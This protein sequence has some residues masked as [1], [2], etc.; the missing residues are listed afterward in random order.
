MDVEALRDSPIGGLVDIDGVDPGT[1]RPFDH[2]AFVPAPLPE[3]VDLTQQ[4]WSQVVNAMGSLGR[5]VQAC[6]QLPN[7]RLLIRPALVKEALSTSAL[8]GTYGTLSDVL[9]A[10]LPESAR[11]TPETREIRAYEMVA[12]QAFQWVEDRP[13]TVGMLSSL[14][15][16]LADAS[17]VPSRDPGQVRQHQ[18][19]IGPEH[20]SVFDARFIP[21]PP[22]IL[23]ETG[24]DDWQRWINE[25]HGL[26]VIVRAALAHYQFESLH[27]FGDGNGRIGR[28]VVLLQLLREGV[29]ATPA[30]TIS[31][32]F[33]QRREL[34]QNHLLAVS[35][36]GDWNP[37]VSFFCQALDTQCAAHVDVAQKLLDWSNGLRADLHARGWGGVIVEVANDLIE[38]PI[39][40]NPWIMSKYGVSAPTAKHATDRLVEIQALQPTVH[41]YPRRFGAA[42]VMDLVDSL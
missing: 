16:L 4:T 24:L 1:S 9:E 7:P 26:P 41:G 36:T 25:D 28:L 8:E 3:V 27:P 5:L 6:A 39:V 11:Q 37:W 42:E 32:W 35:R 31:P 2:F 15:K 40:T 22:G 19:I 12:E 29:L 17:R 33:L 21:P 20:G 23:L 14:Q 13:I 30:L 38:W 18:V 10:R 34:Y